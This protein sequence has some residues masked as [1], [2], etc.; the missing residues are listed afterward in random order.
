[1]SVAAEPPV[2]PTV[3]ETPRLRLRHLATDDAPFILALLND[4]L[5]ISKI[6]A[7]KLELEKLDFDLRLLLEDFAAPLALR[8][9][10][11]CQYSAMASS[12][13]P[14]RASSNARG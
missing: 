3:I 10:L 12:Q 2:S 6:E 8:A 7:G 13:R 5:D 14:L 11:T 9:G 1:M 4:L